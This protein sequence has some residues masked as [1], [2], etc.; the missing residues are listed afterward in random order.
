MSETN[1]QRMRRI[2]EEESSITAMEQAIRRFRNG[3][4]TYRQ[5]IA[6]IDEAT[7]QR[8]VA[9]RPQSHTPEIQT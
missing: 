5:T 1:E 9:I 7:E 4:S 8:I 2:A 6:D 3:Q